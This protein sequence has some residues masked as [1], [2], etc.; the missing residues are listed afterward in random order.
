MLAQAINSRKPTAASS[1][2]NPCFV[3]RRTKLFLNGSTLVLHPSRCRPVRGSTAAATPAR[4]ALA[5]SSVTP[6][7]SRPITFNE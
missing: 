3:L 5:C 2:H 7:R 4:F 6:G 1:S